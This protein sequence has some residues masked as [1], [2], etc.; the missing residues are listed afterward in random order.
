V[1]KVRRN[2]DKNKRII[3]LVPAAGKAARLSPLPF[4]KE[5][6]PIGYMRSKENDELR[7]KPVCLYLLEN[8]KIGGITDVYIILRKGKWDIPAYLGDG[9]LL[10]M[11]FA[12]L[13]MNLPLGVPYTLSQAFP[14]TRDAIV[15]F[16]FPDII[17]QPENAFQ[18]L[19]DR[20]DISK[21]DVVLGLFPVDKPNRFHMV[22]LGHNGSIDKI[23]KNPTETHLKYTWII[24][25][26]TQ[27]FSHFIQINLENIDRKKEKIELGERA[28][29]KREL[30]L[31]DIIQKAIDTK[32]KVEGVIFSQGS[33]IDVGTSEGLICALKQDSD[34]P[35][36]V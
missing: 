3:G 22:E 30:H 31:S 36:K 13:L 33:C 21:A 26:W 16:G 28:F 8:M 10:G 25:V 9:S 18:E 5:L 12:Y 23:V 4:S 6:Y 32:L 1:T 27:A 29:N 19:L 14:F 35:N 7:P 15:A 11:N 20:H 2:V 17:F 24:A 34:N